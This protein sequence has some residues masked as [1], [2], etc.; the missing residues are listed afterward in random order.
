VNGI[1]TFKNNREFALHLQHTFGRWRSTGLGE[2]QK[3]RGR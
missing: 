2:K 1:E 3:K